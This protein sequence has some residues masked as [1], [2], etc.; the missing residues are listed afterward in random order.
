MDFVVGNSNK[1]PKLGLE[2]NNQLSLQCVDI[3]K[4]RFFLKM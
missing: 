2:G 3:A 1:L 4:L